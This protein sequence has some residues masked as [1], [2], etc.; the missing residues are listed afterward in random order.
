VAGRWMAL[1]DLVRA[2]EAEVRGTVQLAEEIGL[3]ALEGD[4]G[5]RFAARLLK[6]GS[7]EPKDPTAAERKRRQR[8]A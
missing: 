4:D 1:A 6:Y 3:V 8:G 5:V 7:W 2:S